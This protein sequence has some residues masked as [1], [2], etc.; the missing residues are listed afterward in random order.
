MN[1][2]TGR[3]K[4]TM[5]LLFA[6]ATIAAATGTQEVRLTPPEI[7]ALARGGADTGTSGVAGIRTTV[8]RGDPSGAGPYTIEIRVPANT[9]I[10]AH[11]HRDDR[12]GVV[13]SGK[14]YFG[15]GDKADEG[16]VKELAPG[17]FYTEPANAPHFA[18][19]R[20]APAVVYITGWGPTDTHYVDATADPRR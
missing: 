15:Y 11:T 2:S 12:S 3:M 7:E 4:A 20:A 5:L 1:A 16:L 9:R 14:W 18:L 13:V 17:S 6:S 19:T 8:L 10:Q